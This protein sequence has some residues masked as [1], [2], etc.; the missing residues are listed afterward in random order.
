MS[1]FFTFI[2]VI[3]AAVGMAGSFVGGVLFLCVMFILIWIQNKD[4]KIKNLNEEN[5]NLRNK[6]YS[7]N[8]KKIT[9]VS[10]RQKIKKSQPQ[11]NTPNSRIQNIIEEKTGIKKSID[12]NIPKIKSHTNNEDI[13]LYIASKNLAA[14][15]GNSS[16]KKTKIIIKFWDYIKENEL[17]DKQNKRLIHCDGK[18]KTICNKDTI[19]SFEVAKIIKENIKPI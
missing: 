6:S 18:I 19:T 17:Q 14:I 9:D 15:V 16:M 2:F 4:K 10:K 3:I 13:E 7:E 11:E 5:E 1:T 8:T 12:V